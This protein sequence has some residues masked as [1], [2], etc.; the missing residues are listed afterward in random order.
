MKFDKYAKQYDSGWMGGASSRFYKDLIKEVDVKENDS[1]LDVGCG[2]G[3]ILNYISDRV[4]INGYGIDVSENMI[5]V[6]KNKDKKCCFKIG[7]SDELP[8]NDSSM[9][10]IIACMA[11][12]HFPNQEKFRKE[13]FRV[14][15]PGGKLYICDPRF[16]GI[17]RWGLNTFCDDAGFCSTKRNIKSFEQDGFKNKGVKKDLYVQVLTFEKI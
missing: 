11:Y 10:V 15:K 16:P 8:F 17:V 5:E 2:T 13:A 4:E 1:V 7:S 6:A 12:H 3:T 14:L 9:D